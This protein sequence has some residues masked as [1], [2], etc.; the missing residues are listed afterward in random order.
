MSTYMYGLKSPRLVKQVVVEFKDGTRGNVYC[1]AF[2]FLFG[3]AYERTA[4]KARRM[5][6]VEHMWD[7]EVRPVFA[8]HI[9]SEDKKLSVGKDV[10]HWLNGA[11]MLFSDGNGT[12]GNGT[13]V[14]KIVEIL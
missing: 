12:N 9:S 6:L 11:P 3:H 13:L 2:Q 4:Y 14:G 5:G 7:G 1:G 8:A 10:F